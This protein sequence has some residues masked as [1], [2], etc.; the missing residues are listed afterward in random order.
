MNLILTFLV[1]QLRS[2]W[3]EAAA[4][5]VRY[6]QH[7][8]VWSDQRWIATVYRVRNEQQP[9]SQPSANPLLSHDVNHRADIGERLGSVDPEN[10]LHDRKILEI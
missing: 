1:R 10:R 7:H 6:Q 5:A 2:L 8:A 3:A 9:V 4:S